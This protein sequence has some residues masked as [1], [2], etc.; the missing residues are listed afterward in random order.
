M[1]LEI[2]A[3]ASSHRIEVVVHTPPASACRQKG[4]TKFVVG[5]IHLIG[6]KHGLKAIFVE[7][8]VVRHQWQTLN[9]R[10]NLLPYLRE[11]GGII[12]VALAEPVHLAAEIVVIVGRRLNERIKGIHYLSTPYNHHAHRTHRTALRISSFKVDCCKIQH[13]EKVKNNFVKIIP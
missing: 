11:N 6:A 10:L 3:T 2:D 7:R 13:R 9:E 1:V 12:G 5:I 8:L 4:A